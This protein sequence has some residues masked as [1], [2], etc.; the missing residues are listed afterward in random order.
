MPKKSTYMG[1]AKVAPPWPIKEP[2]KT[3]R[4]ADGRQ[5]GEDQ[6]GIDHASPCALV[7]SRQLVGETSRRPATGGED[8]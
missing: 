3:R 8:L 7:K 6:Q 4:N 1:T 2:H 5:Q